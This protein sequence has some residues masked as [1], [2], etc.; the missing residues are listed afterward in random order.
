ML[1]KYRQRFIQPRFDHIGTDNH[2]PRFSLR[3]K[4]SVSLSSIVDC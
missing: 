1:R 3:V 2:L 4:I